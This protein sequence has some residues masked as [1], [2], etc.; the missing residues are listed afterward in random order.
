MGIGASVQHPSR[1]RA[2]NGLILDGMKPNRVAVAQSDGRRVVVAR[3][4]QSL[5]GGRDVSQAVVQAPIPRESFESM[6]T[7]MRVDAAD[8]FALPLP[9]SEESVVREYYDMHPNA[10]YANV[11]SFAKSLLPNW[12][13]E[14]LRAITTLLIT[15]GPPQNNFAF[16]EYQTEKQFIEEQVAA[17]GRPEPYI[18]YPQEVYDRWEALIVRANAVRQ[19]L[20]AQ[21]IPVP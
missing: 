19:Q 1:M 3:E 8:E 15:G 18:V 11:R 2:P 21:G 5:V 7:R 12:S 6:W 10:P 4:G 13:A 20:A 17:A 16:S 14:A 9:D